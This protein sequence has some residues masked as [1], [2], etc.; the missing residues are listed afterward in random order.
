MQDWKFI[1]VH[2]DTYD[3]LK[4]LGQ[5]G[6]SFNDIIRRLLVDSQNASNRPTDKEVKEVSRDE[7]KARLKKFDSHSKAITRLVKENVRYSPGGPE[8]E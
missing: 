6:D 5:F 1:R 8:R 4:V 2:E 7:I 3:D